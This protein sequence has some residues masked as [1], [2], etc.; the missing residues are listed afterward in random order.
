MIEHGNPFLSY[1]IEYEREF[2]LLTIH[3]YRADSEKR[4]PLP[5]Y[6]TRANLVVIS[7][8]KKIIIIIHR[9]SRFP[10]FPW[11]DKTE[12][13]KRAAVEGCN[14]GRVFDPIDRSIGSNEGDRIS[15]AEATV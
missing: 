5:H 2:F 6:E 8:K 13:I 12:T 4:L 14:G 9:N 3:R 11:R 1:E 15:L 10:S 7:S